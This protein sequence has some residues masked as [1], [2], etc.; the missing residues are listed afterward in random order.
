MLGGWVGTGMA[1][2]LLARLWKGRSALLWA[3]IALV[4]YGI[5]EDPPVGALLEGGRPPPWRERL[6]DMAVSIVIVGALVA[7]ALGMLPARHSG[8]VRPGGRRRG[9]GDGGSPSASPVAELMLCP[10]C[11]ESIR[12]DAA[13][14]PYCGHKFAT[15]S[16]A[17]ATTERPGP[18]TR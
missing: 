16:A 14:C 7:L 18:P 2:G 10:T 1:A 4:L 8:H 9:R 3:L 15:T 13:V 11:V 12:A 17:A 6:P 5:I